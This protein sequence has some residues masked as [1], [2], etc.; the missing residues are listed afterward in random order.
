MNVAGTGV[1]AGA[2]VVAVG[3]TTVT[4][5]ATSTAGVA[6]AAAITFTQDLTLDNATINSGQT[7]TITAKSLTAPNA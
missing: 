2:T 5:S 6:N 4:L 1:P 3:G 7:V